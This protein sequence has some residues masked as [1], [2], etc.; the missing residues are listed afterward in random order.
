MS[1]AQHDEVIRFLL[2]QK[3]L[4]ESLK[5]PEDKSHV[6]LLPDDILKRQGDFD[7]HREDY[8]FH[9]QGPDRLRRP[10]DNLTVTIIRETYKLLI[11]FIFILVIDRKLKWVRPSFQSTPH[12][13]WTPR[14][15]NA[16]FI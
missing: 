2:K 14:P 10:W 15:S 11:C 9:E 8:I 1:D 4:V 12:F 5:E 7:A 13:K 3:H 16:Q 6:L